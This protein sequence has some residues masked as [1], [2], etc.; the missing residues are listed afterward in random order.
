ML[1]FVWHKK[2][3][4]DIL[5]LHTFSNAFQPVLTFLFTW[6]P[7]HT[8]WFHYISIW[9]PRA[10]GCIPQAATYTFNHMHRSA[11]NSQRAHTHTHRHRRG[12]FLSRTFV[13]TA[14]KKITT[15]YN[16]PLIQRDRSYTE[17][18]VE[19]SAHRCSPP[20]LQFDRVEHGGATKAHWNRQ[21]CQH[22]LGGANSFRLGTNCD[23]FGFLVCDFP[24]DSE[25]RIANRQQQQLIMAHDHLIAIHFEVD[26]IVEKLY[27]FTGN[28]ERL[29]EPKN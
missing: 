16:P 21:K 29:D 8:E 20:R 5:N 24:D 26:K 9:L 22:R 18:R 10:G 23:H 3:A 7:P 4:A 13:C 6:L 15:K 25:I 17:S 2:C 1:T 19:L 27:R 11:S 12:Q 14:P 28:H